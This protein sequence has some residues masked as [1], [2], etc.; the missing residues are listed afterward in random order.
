MSLQRLR[1]IPALLC[2]LAIAAISVL[3]LG[4]SVSYADVTT[5]NRTAGGPSTY[6]WY[7]SDASTS[8]GWVIAHDPIGNS[9]ENTYGVSYF[10]S[11]PATSGTSFNALHQTC[12][13][14]DLGVS[15]ISGSH[16]AFDYNSF[17]GCNGDP[18]NVILTIE[19]GT[20]QSPSINWGG[21]VPGSFSKI[22]SAS[23]R[24]GSSLPVSDAGLPSV[25]AGN[26]I[27]T[28]AQ[29]AGVHRAAGFTEQQLI[30]ITA[31]ALA[32]SGG[33]VNAVNRNPNPIS[34]DIG[35]DQ[36]ND[37]AHPSYDRNV[38]GTNPLY[39]T[40]AAHDIFVAANGF[41]PWSTYNSGVYSRYLDRATKGVADSGG[42][43]LAL[44][45][46]SGGI[47][48]PNDKNGDGIP[49]VTPNSAQQDNCSF[50]LNPLNVLKCLFLPTDGSFSQ[51]TQLKDNI[52]TKPP[53]SVLTASVS[54]TRA[55]FG[56][57]GACQPTPN[58]DPGCRQDNSASISFDPLQPGARHTNFDFSPLKKA[59]EA[60][61]NGAYQTILTILRLGLW[62]GFTFYVFKRISQSF[63][64]KETGNTE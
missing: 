24:N 19:V 2:S 40:T 58:G 55:I 33:R 20:C 43:S 31:I 8:N 62:A 61:D 63:G 47:A 17:Q 27:L 51:W 32:E 22:V 59:S 54:Y 46:C 26:C 10:L 23:F 37:K 12:G 36:I 52:T 3:F 9:T 64:S 56:Q 1:R 18:A 39:N 60:A 28:D 48:N 29:I 53:L 16:G 30:P 21:C 25:T 34:Y 44:A 57:Y 4:S 38:L 35:L 7:W 6:G 41:T 49:D 11:S 45:N 14:R 50:S 13:T 42:Q 15:G 5:Y